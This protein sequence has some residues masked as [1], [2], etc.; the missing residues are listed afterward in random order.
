M[1]DSNPFSRS[2]RSLR[3]TT[4][5]VM[6]IGAVA[7]LVLVMA[8]SWLDSLAVE[9]YRANF[10]DEQ[11][12][13]TGI[14]ARALSENLDETYLQRTELAGD[15][16]TTLLG[17]QATSP[18]ALRLVLVN[19]ARV[20]LI[21]LVLFEPDGSVV[22]KQLYGPI[23]DVE[24][25]PDVK[26]TVQVLFSLPDLVQNPQTHLA[27]APYRDGFSVVVYRPLIGSNQ[28]L[29]I[30]VA[31]GDL[32]GPIGR[33]VEPISAGRLGSATIIDQQGVVLFASEDTEVGSDLLAGL[34]GR[35]RRRL[36]Y[37]A[38]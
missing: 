37:D 8:V 32:A 25:I 19:H 9:R 16:L 5:A 23:T 21:P 33:F 1:T 4:W 17:Q 2:T 15:Q 12:A 36:R 28:V 7:M 31:F 20:D 24:D 11:A 22:A 18:T 6:V 13:I 3:A 34:E 27:I 29:G 38:C 10:N 26:D 35:A 14:A 30:L